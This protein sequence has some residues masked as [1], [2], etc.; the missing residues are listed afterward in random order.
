MKTAWAKNKTT[1]I[2]SEMTAEDLFF[3]PLTS[4]F[5]EVCGN[6]AAKS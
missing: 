2:S 4:P 3:T 5:I 1:N 6:V